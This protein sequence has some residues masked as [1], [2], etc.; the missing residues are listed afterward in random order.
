MRARLAS[1]AEFWWDACVLALFPAAAAGFYIMFAADYPLA[2]AARDPF[3]L[4]SY[5]TLGVGTCV[6][7]AHWIRLIRRYPK[8]RDDVWPMRMHSVRMLSLGGLWLSFIFCHAC[9]IFVA[10]GLAVGTVKRL[11]ARARVTPTA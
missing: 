11:L 2:Q 8:S 10:L 4:G 3:V 7:A 6:F 1:R 9:G 5:A